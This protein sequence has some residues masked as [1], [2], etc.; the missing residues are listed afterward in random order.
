MSIRIIDIKINGPQAD[1]VLAAPTI[2][3]LQVRDVD[4]VAIREAARQG[5]SG[6]GLSSKNGP[7]PVDADGESPAELLTGAK[8]VH[9]YRLDLKLLSTRQ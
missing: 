9:E 6:A 8:P 3:E 5:L 7:Y 1:V 4:Q 2:Q